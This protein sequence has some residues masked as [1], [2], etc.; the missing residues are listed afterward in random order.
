LLTW[1]VLIWAWRFSQPVLMQTI[2]LDEATRP[3]EVPGRA[4]ILD[5][6]PAGRTIITN[7]PHL[8]ALS[9]WD[10]G[11]GQP[12]DEIPQAEHSLRRA[13]AEQCI[14]ATVL[15][16][17]ANPPTIPKSQ[18]RSGNRSY[19]VAC[20]GRFANE[21][22]FAGTWEAR[23]GATQNEGDLRTVR[24]ILQLCDALSGKVRGRITICGSILAA[25]IAPG[26]DLLALSCVLHDPRADRLKRWLGGE[27]ART[28]LPDREATLIVDLSSGR[29]LADLPACEDLAFSADGKRLATYAAQEQEVQ[30]WRLPPRWTAG[31]RWHWLQSL[32]STTL[33]A[34]LGLAAGLW[35]A[36][37][38]FVHWSDAQTNRFFCRAMHPA[39]FIA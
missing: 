10:I 11:T 1:L 39:D 6:G 9:G 29:A 32:N 31:V 22:S 16:K 26:G 37:M 36:F 15:R 28:L 2:S 14:V 12:L 34:L 30:V 25:A 33:F 5:F 24:E 17:T 13:G 27:W 18:Q 21:S 35:T 3:A 38:V 8:Q 4:A 7:Y 20:G 23:S 19:T